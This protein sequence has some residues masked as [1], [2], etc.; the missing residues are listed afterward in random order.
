M[1]IFLME[2]KKRDGKLST[3]LY[4][5][6]AIISL[7]FSW[8][9]IFGLIVSIVAIIGCGVALKKS[10]SNHGLVIA[11]LVMGILALL[12]ALAI[13]LFS[14]AF[15]SLLGAS[16][17]ITDN[18]DI[19]Q[20]ID[21][22]EV[23]TIGDVYITAE[24]WDSDSEIDGLQFD[25]RPKD[26]DDKIVE[27]DGSVTIQLW[28]RVCTESNDYFCASWAC[29]MKDK[30]LLEAW[31]IPITKSDFKSFLGTKI[32]AEYQKYKLSGDE[33]SLGCVQI[34]LTTP[35]GKQFK[36]SSDSVFLAEF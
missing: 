33:Y 10:E 20:N 3:V 15:L 16:S 17:S 19:V 23:S 1:I 7:V 4:F 5:I 29:T 24:T 26:K 13:T 30:D 35:D 2:K 28:K 22:R 6:L 9:P 14:V 27:T 34:T 8:V 21:Q 18:K 32:R 11:G 25:L 12:I 31:T 36:S